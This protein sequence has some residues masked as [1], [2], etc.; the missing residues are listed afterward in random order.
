MNRKQRKTYDEVIA[1]LQACSG[2]QSF[3]PIEVNGRMEKIVRAYAEMGRGAPEILRTI[4]A[5][6]KEFWQHEGCGLFKRGDK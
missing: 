6:N 2:G 1:A 4:Q 3:P 5:I